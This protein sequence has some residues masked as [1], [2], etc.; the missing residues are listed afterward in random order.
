MGKEEAVAMSPWTYDDGGRKAA[1]FV[2]STGDCVCRAIAIAAQRPYREIY[3]L[4]KVRRRRAP[5]TTGA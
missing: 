1:G 3:D 2:G 4:I 5:G